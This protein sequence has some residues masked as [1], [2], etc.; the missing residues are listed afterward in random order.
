VQL[1][2]GEWLAAETLVWAGGVRAPQ[3]LHDSGLPTGAGGRVQVDQFQRT[4]GHLNIY[5]V[6]DSALLLDK[7]TGRPVPPTADGALRSG[8]TAAFALMATL[9]GHDPER[10]LQPMTRNAVSV[11]QHQGAATLLGFTLKGHA[12]RAL[13]ALI[14]WEYRQ[15]ITRLHGYSIATVL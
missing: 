4:E 13:K 12:A 1:K 10:V 14:E 9:Q 2:S 7:T 15:S 8:E 3:L 5:A 11:G 6:G